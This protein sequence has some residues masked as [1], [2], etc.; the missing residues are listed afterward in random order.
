M[1]IIT[2]DDINFLIL[3]YLQGEGF[4]H[5]AFTFQN[6]AKIAIPCELSSEIEAEFDCRN[7]LEGGLG[8]GFNGKVKKIIETTK[9]GLTKIIEEGIKAIYMDHHGLT[10]SCKK[11]FKLSEP[12]VCQI[13]E[14]KLGFKALDTV[15]GNHLSVFCGTT[16]V[17][18][19]EN[20]I[21]RYENSNNGCKITDGLLKSNNSCE[22]THADKEN[23]SNVEPSHLKSP[24]LVKNYKSTACKTETDEITAISTFKKYFAI[25][26]HHGKLS[27]YDEKLAKKS[28][29]EI[30][31][32]PIL[33]IKESGERLAIAAYNGNVYLHTPFEEKTHK[34]KGNLK[35]KVHKNV[36]YDVAWIGND[37]IA[38]C[39]ADQSVTIIDTQNLKTLQ[40]ALDSEQTV[41][42]VNLGYTGK[43]NR[44]T[45]LAVGGDSGIAT[46][47][48]VQGAIDSQ[49]NKTI[50]TPV[51][52]KHGKEVIDMKFAD[53]DL[54]TVSFDKRFRIYDLEKWVAAEEYIQDAPI[55][56]LQYIERNNI[57][58]TGSTL[59]NAEQ[60]QDT[61]GLSNVVFYDKRIG[62]IKRFRGNS[63]VY[64]ISVCEIDNLICV[65]FVEDVP[66]V[67][68]MRWI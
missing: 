20:R 15:R 65:S 14:L 27:I 31:C 47:W 11:P 21:F 1:I 63:E 6:E 59:R 17:S 53:K 49:L 25:G 50:E 64:N 60:K 13:K 28:S 39:S 58:V 34:C 48:N 3:R 2:D 12:H 45:L 42:A 4:V 67:V 22:N 40:M 18:T 33:A 54:A 32:G 56:V 44:D 51:K 29:I 43:S 30:G 62:E 10:S 19:F 35:F 24:F 38:S 57:F 55:Q 46:I 9:I 26:T 5:T 23:I 36:V 52:F 8:D 68:D 61:N 16:L 37:F 7:E 41:L 66:M